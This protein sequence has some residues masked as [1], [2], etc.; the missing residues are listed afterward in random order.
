MCQFQSFYIVFG[1]AANNWLNLAVA[2]ELHSLLC[3]SR[4]FKKYQ[5]P[6][7]KRVMFTALSVYAYSCFIA[8]WALWSD[9][10]DNFPHK[11][12]TFSGLGC[13]PLEYS[14]HSSIFSF[15][16]YIQNIRELQLT[17][18]P[19]KWSGRKIL[20]PHAT[21]NVREVSGADWTIRAVRR[22]EILR[23]HAT[24]NLP[25]VSG[26]DWTIRAVRR[27]KIWSPHATMNLPERGR[28]DNTSSETGTMCEVV[29]EK[30]NELS[31]WPD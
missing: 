26:A 31:C 24:L 16:V 28:S 22:R 5:M 3:A 4:R 21:L 8:S 27:R 10:F 15:S 11:T 19:R 23:P 18:P 30:K 29:A 20:R 13:M 9:R 7:T 14:R 25:E 1:V 2:W 17:C 12:M 6:S